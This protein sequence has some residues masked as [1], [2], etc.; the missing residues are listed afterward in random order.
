MA[1]LLLA[2]IPYLLVFT[3][4][5][6]MLLRNRGTG[7]HDKKQ[8]PDR[9]Y[10]LSVIIPVK[11]EAGNIR[12]LLSDL[13]AQSLDHALYEIIIIDDA[14]TDATPAILR[15][16]QGK[17]PFIKIIT[18]AGGGKKKALGLGLQKAGGDYIVTTDGDC[19]IHPGWLSDIYSF[20]RAA[21]ADMIIGPVDII[22]TGRVLNGFV[23]LEF[24][25]L[26]AV[27]EAFAK[28]GRP[29]LCNGANLC[30]K[31]PGAGKY[32]SMIKEHISSGDDIFLMESFKAANKKIS[33]LDTS[34][35]RV[36]T[37]GPASLPEFLSQRARWSSKSISYSD[38]ALAGITALVFATNTLICF[39]VVASLIIPG[40][41]LSVLLMYIMKS[42][43]DFLLLSYVTVKRG[44]QQLLY[45]FVPAQLLYP[46]YIF[47]AGLAGIIKGLFSLQYSKSEKRTGKYK[48]LP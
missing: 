45:L 5:R 19:R 21:N 13:A 33:W 10:M 39:A 32:P 3:G 37:Y 41:W 28:N 4:I 47:T 38:P 24:L 42:V 8:Q 16:W 14:S 27:T 22:R 30:F 43:P 44:R 48:P 40:L 29:V 12:L 26:Q 46:F 36:K 31:N 1:W 25:S 6:I 20:I 2:L 17:R 7:R 34:A 9:P 15:S 18:G 35:S 23:Q 11:N